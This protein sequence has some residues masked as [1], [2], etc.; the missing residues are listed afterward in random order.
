MSGHDWLKLIEISG[1]FLTEP[2]LR[3][4]FPDGLNTI[5]TYDR[6]RLRSTYGEWER[7][8]EAE[9]DDLPEVH[10]A[11]IDEVVTGGLEFDARVVRTHEDMPVRLK[12][13]L[14]EH[15]ITLQ[16][17]LALVD[18]SGDENGLFLISIVEPGM[19]L[20]ETTIEEGYASTPLERMVTLL[21]GVGLALH[22]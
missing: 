19:N 17:D 8:V 18:R 10:R 11:W 21:R 14:P 16:P 22:G 20:D 2:V 6:R 1:P 12:F 3:D 5:D 15:G 4:V 9:E 13:D 7:C